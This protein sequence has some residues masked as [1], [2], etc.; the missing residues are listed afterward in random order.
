MILHGLSIQGYK[1]FGKKIR[2]QNL[3]DVNVFI[4]ANNVGKSNILKAIQTHLPEIIGKKKYEGFNKLT[5]FNHKNSEKVIRLGLQ[6]PEEKLQE[7]NEIQ[8][9]NKIKQIKEDFWVYKE[10]S[11]NQ[12]ATDTKNIEKYF[13]ANHDLSGVMKSIEPLVS[14]GDPTVR[15]QRFVTF[16]TD[17]LVPKQLTVVTIDPF[18]KITISRTDEADPFISALRELQHPDSNDRDKYLKQNKQFEDIN[19]FIRNVLNDPTAKLEIPGTTNDVTVILNNG[20]RIHSIQD[21][22]TGIHEVIIFA[23]KVTLC[24]N[25][26]ICID[27]PEIHL[28]PI[29]QKRLISF[30][31]NN[32]QSNKNQYFIATHSN[33]FIDESGINIY[34]CRMDSDGNTSCEPTPDLRSKKSIIDDL[35]YKASDILQTNCIIWVEGPSDRIYVKHWLSLFCDF[36]EGM[37]FSIMFY[38]G[39]LLSHL[40][41]DQTNEIANQLIELSHINKNAAI[42]I[43]SDKDEENTD[44]HE[45][46]K[47]I[48][49]AF[50]DNDGFCWITEG[51]TI[52]NYLNGTILNRVTK[53]ILANEW[54]KYAKLDKFF[55]NPPKVSIAHKAVELCAEKDKLDAHVQ[56]Q[57]AHLIDFIKK[58]NGIKPG[59]QSTI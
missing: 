22:G 41:F 57:I 9:L 2:I 19:N 17:K 45:T 35:G 11:S 52:E 8:I 20:T 46:K 30:L 27:E 59:K 25:T 5:D 24:E 53:R 31:K 54:T 44:I 38:G 26:L 32:A 3:A 50:E 39:S 40:D 18:R 12:I 21:V 49:T 7:I 16:L 34:H 47:R 56:K 36:K 23:I 42:L 6:F 13:A 58:C 33:S 55:K 28:H 43:D 15:T 1:S 14:Y 51:R 4:G 48:K 37:H 10:I 29:M